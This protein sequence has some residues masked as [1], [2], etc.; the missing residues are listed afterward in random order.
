[1]TL[2]TLPTI[3][4]TLTVLHYLQSV[5]HTSSKARYIPLLPAHSYQTVHVQEACRQGRDVGGAAQHFPPVPGILNLT[6]WAPHPPS[7]DALPPRLPLL[8]EALEKTAAV[9][10]LAREDRLALPLSPQMKA[11]PQTERA[12]VVCASALLRRWQVSTPAVSPERTPRVLLRRSLSR[13]V[14]FSSAQKATSSTPCA[15]SGTSS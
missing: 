13:V 8:L 5:V 4:A 3:D 1:M 11:P 7:V 10:R 2:T 12:Q 9:P 6:T 15:T 14:L